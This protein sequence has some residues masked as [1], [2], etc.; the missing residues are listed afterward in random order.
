MAPAQALS[1]FSPA[2]LSY[3]HT[4]L[5]HI[6]PIRS[7][8]RQSTQFRPLAA[9]TDI[10]PAA[11]G[12]ARICFA[13]GTE[14]IVGVKAEVEQT[15]WQTGGSPVD[16]ESEPSRLGR[17][18]DG[19]VDKM[20][21]GH[22]TSKPEKTGA[23][24]SDWVEMS[25]DVPGCRDDDPL[26][27]FLSAMLREALLAAGELVDRLW[28][29]R[30]WHWKLHVDVRTAGTMDSSGCTHEWLTR[31][32][33][34]SSFIATSIISHPAPILDH[35][36]CSPLDPATGSCL[37]VRRRPFVQRRLGGCHTNLSSSDNVSNRTK[38]PRV[39]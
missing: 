18:T 21:E 7:D 32:C 10:L 36:P 8:S 19:D 29:N 11:N 34:D 5:A 35:P 27:V 30:R 15:T 28:I 33:S 31:P 25:I 26:P 20:G 24:H 16:A 23:G 1:L 37:R 17:A 4:S 13:D 3:L 14:A 6:P 38:Y 9:E 12:S 22:E 39:C 2:E